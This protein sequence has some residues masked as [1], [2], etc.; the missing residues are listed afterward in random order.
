MITNFE[1]QKSDVLKPFLILDLTSGKCILENLNLLVKQCKLI[2]SS[3]ELCSKDIS[4]VN[5]VLVIFLEFFNFLV[6]LFDD[7]GQLLNFIVKLKFGLFS[8]LEFFL[9]RFQ[10]TVD[11]INF[12]TLFSFF[13]MDLGQS[14][15]LGLNFIF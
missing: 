6:G 11:N 9:V 3:N 4:L 5:N 2:I 8:Y 12:F 13:V 15:I 10:I 14:L 7:I 1:F